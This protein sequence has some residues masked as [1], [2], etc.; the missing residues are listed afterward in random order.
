[1]AVKGRE[2]CVNEQDCLSFRFQVIITN[3]PHTPSLYKAG[4]AM[5]QA[6]SP[7]KSNGVSPFIVLGLSEGNPTFQMDRITGDGQIVCGSFAGFSY[8]LSCMVV[9]IGQR[10][11]Q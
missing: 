6:C 10:A 4:Q 3:S 11:F 7:T 9:Q 5:P 1:M 2:G 8:A